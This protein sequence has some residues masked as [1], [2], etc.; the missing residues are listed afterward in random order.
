MTK[1][2]VF[3]IALG[4]IISC[5][6]KAVKVNKDFPIVQELKANLIPINEILKYGGI[7]KLK[8]Y[9]VLRDVSETCKVFYY[10]YKYPEF[11]FLYTFANKGQGP[12]EHISASTVYDTP[13]NFI[14][15]RDQGDKFF[16]YQL[17]DTSSNLIYS[18]IV[19]SDI[20]PSFLIMAHTQID[21]DLY[22]G[23]IQNGKSSRQALICFKTKKI[24]HNIPSAFNLEKELGNKYYPTF[25]ACL[26]TSNNKRFACGYR[27]MDLIEFGSIQNNQIVITNRVGIKKAPKFHLYGPGKPDGYDSNYLYN[28]VYYEDMICGEKYVYTLYANKPIGD[29]ENGHSL[30]IEVYSWDGRSVALFKLDKSISKFIVDEE[31]Q[32]IYGYDFDN[33]ED[34]LYSFKYDI[35]D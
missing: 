5:N 10:V 7:Y 11:Q 21:D 25:D 26:M 9:I 3:I 13:D 15:F 24:I 31:L 18:S 32:T 12:N 35:P 23:R 1:K 8:D 29:L 28:T 19:K 20:D 17:T 2:V 34:F 33:S 30:M 14:T 22:L 16:T 27:L 6:N 4:C